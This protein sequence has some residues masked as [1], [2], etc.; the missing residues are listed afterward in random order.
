MTNISPIPGG[1]FLTIISIG[2]SEKPGDITQLVFVTGVSEFYFRSF[3]SG[4][5]SIPDFTLVKG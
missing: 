1:K 3:Y 4:A 5:S 2:P